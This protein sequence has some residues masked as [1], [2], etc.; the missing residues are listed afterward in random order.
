MINTHEKLMVALVDKHI[1]REQLLDK[2]QQ[3]GY[4]GEELKMSDLLCAFGRTDYYINGK[5]HWAEDREIS[6]QEYFEILAD[7]LNIN[8]IGR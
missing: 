2:L 8:F 7:E 5:R 4:M 1:S 6:E 3:H